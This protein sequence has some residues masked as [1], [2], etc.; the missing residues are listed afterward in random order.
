MIGN[1]RDAAKGVDS[2]D[3]DGAAVCADGDPL[4]VGSPLGVDDVCGGD[5]A[6]ELVSMP[7]GGGG[8]RGGRVAKGAGEGQLKDVES[9]AERIG[10]EEEATTGAE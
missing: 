1:R 8:G 10:G 5:A 4:G 7:N 3:V 2:I 6:Q 9:M